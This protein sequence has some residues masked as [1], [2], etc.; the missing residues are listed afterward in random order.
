MRPPII[1]VFSKQIARNKKGVTPKENALLEATQTVLKT[2]DE[3]QA[4]IDTKG[5]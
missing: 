4:E 1:V 2:F 5:L 3:G